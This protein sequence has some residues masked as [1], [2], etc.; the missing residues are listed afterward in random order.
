MNFDKYLIQHLTF[1]TTVTSLCL[2]QEKLKPTPLQNLEDKQ[3][4]LWELWKLR[5]LTLKW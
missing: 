5:I 3:D 2:S 4:V 1:P